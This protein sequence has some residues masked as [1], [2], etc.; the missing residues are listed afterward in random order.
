MSGLVTTWEPEK[1][2]KGRPVEIGTELLQVANDQ[3]EWEM[4]V[5][6]PDDDMGPILEAQSK[7][8]KEIASGTKPVGSTLEAYFVPATGPEHRYIGFVRRVAA[9]ADTV[10]GKHVVKV[11]VG[12]SKEVREEFLKDQN[13][14]PGAEVRARIQC[15]NA[16]LAYVLLRDVVHVF[17]ETVLF[18]WP[19]MN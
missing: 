15:G 14:R 12:F 17:Y 4:E 7:L 8:Q 11:T 19:F 13:L 9:K 2:L 5:E 6:V 16:R 1:N 3:G 10:E 18:R